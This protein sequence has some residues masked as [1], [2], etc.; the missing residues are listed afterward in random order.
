VNNTDVEVASP[1]SKLTCPSNL[2]GWLECCS[3]TN[4]DVDYGTCCSW[5]M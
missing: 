5:Y 1:G 4:K 2:I 3:R